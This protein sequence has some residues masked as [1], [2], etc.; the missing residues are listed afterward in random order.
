M[1]KPR[2]PA[3]KG[4]DEVPT[5]Q[6]ASVARRNGLPPI[7]PPLAGDGDARD[8]GDLQRTV[9]AL[10]D[11][12]DLLVSVVNSFADPIFVKDIDG[13]YVFA[14][15]SFGDLYG[16]PTAYFPGRSD[17]DFMPGLVAA[18]NRDSDLSVLHAAAPV[19]VDRVVAG[20]DG[21]AREFLVTTTRWQ[22][23]GILAGV[24]G[25]ARDVTE[26]RIAERQMRE[27]EAGVWHSARI[28]A[29]GEAA[30]AM[31]HELAQPLTAAASYVRGVCL[32]LDAPGRFDRARI[33]KTLE[34]GLAAIARSSD[35]V[36]GL[37]RMLRKQPRLRRMLDVNGAVR[38][39][40]ALGAI[41][42]DR[43]PGARLA[44]DLAEHLP[45]IMADR[46]ELQQVVM[47]LVRN[48]VQAMDLD[49]LATRRL[50]VTTAAAG[51]S[52]AITVS[53][54]GPGL[55]A[56]VA[57]NLFEPFLTTKRD[58]VGLG[59][60]ICRSITEAHGGRIAIAS[61]KAGT[62]ATVSLPA[63]PATRGTEDA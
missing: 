26:A 48:A 35:I 15:E 52:V 23:Q 55:P 51:G 32:V 53:D 5:K 10:R 63:L 36:S 1:R 20:A 17:A 28:V 6:T 4:T 27:R 9:A 43:R 31:A 60:S 37:R 40:V 41:G 45:R 38:E 25:V 56:L 7:E 24:V 49:G 54:T 62:T 12:R 42:F 3:P 13:R 44:F 29:L 50:G 16:K 22:R 46:T 34:S 33:Q 59:L 61:G 58:G 11:E 47:N 8:P 21:A 2:R 57:G 30:A 19:S 18:A 39:A 14:N